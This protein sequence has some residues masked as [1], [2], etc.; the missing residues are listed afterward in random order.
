VGV[1]LSAAKMSTPELFF[2]LFEW[3]TGANGQAHLSRGHG[4]FVSFEGDLR[5]AYAC[6]ACRTLVW[7]P[8][9]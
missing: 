3:H 7:L 8:A 1:L 9:V 2:G 5:M 4:G 6:P